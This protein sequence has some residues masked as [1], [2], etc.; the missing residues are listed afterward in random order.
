[1]KGLAGANSRETPIGIMPTAEAIGAR[2]LGLSDR[3]TEALL[4]VNR[5]EWMQEA[6]DQEQ[7]LKEFGD[8]LPPEIRRELQALKQRLE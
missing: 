3:D 6:Q 4:S 5:D 1:V 2:D 7:F 8:R